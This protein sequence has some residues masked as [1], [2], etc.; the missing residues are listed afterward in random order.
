M[1]FESAKKMDMHQK[2]S[3]EE[4][5]RD[6]MNVKGSYLMPLDMIKIVTKPASQEIK[7]KTPKDGLHFESKEDSLSY[8]KV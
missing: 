4:S 5:T 3:K 8:I 1:N 2:E 7:E 6:E